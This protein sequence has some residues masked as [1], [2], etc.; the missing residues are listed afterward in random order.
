M[1]LRPSTEQEFFGRQLDL[2]T[3]TCVLD[4]RTNLP[5]SVASSASRKPSAHANMCVTEEHKQNLSHAQKELL[6]WHCWLGHLGCKTIQMLLRSRVLGES[7]LKR[8]AGKCSVPKCASCQYGKR[9]QR[10]GPREHQFESKKGPLNRKTFNQDNKGF[11][12]TTSMQHTRE[13]SMSH[14]GVQR[15]T[16]C[17]WEAASS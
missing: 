17:T 16:K 5:I 8:A 14:K 12:W 7:N 10:A 3:I 11:Q 2:P 1:Q 6:C 15:R 9:K 13:D 4:E